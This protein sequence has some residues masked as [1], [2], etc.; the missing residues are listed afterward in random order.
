MKIQLGRRSL[1]IIPEDINSVNVD[2]RDTAYIEEVLGLRKDGDSVKLIRRNASGLSC[3]AYL[4]TERVAWPP[5]TSDYCT[6]DHRTDTW[7]DRSIVTDEHGKVLQDMCTRCCECGKA[8]RP[9]EQ[10]SDEKNSSQPDNTN[11]LV[12][13]YFKRWYNTTTDTASHDT[14]LKTFLRDL[15]LEA[16][17]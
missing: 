2:E 7:F 9:S 13:R 8:V 6:C 11:E 1:R 17:M 14:C 16:R 5:R 4:E 10:D 12:E 15:I 3:I